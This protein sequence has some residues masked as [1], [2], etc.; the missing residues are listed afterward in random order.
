MRF[1]FVLLSALFLW[2]G[3][4]LQA[5]I[6]NCSISNLTATLSAPDPTTPCKYFVTLDFDH[7][8][9]TNQFSVKGNGT[10][11]GLFPYSQLPVQLGP[12]MAGT[13]PNVL[14]FIV[15]DAV[16][17]D[18]KAQVLLTLPACNS[19]T[20]NIDSLTVMPGDCI[21][22][23]NKYKLK[24]SFAVVNP[25]NQFVEMW[26]GNGQY[27]GLFP[28]SQLPVVVD[29]PA[30]GNTFDVLKVCMNDNPNCCK[31]LEFQA[32][33]CPGNNCGINN[34]DLSTDGCTND[35]TYRVKLNFQY[36]NPAQSDSFAVY[37]NGN[38][39]ANYAFGQ[40]PLVIPNFP[41]NGGP[42]DEIKIC[43][44]GSPAIPPC[45]VTRFIQ[46]PAC[47]PYPP[48]GVRDVVV[49]PGDC[50]S[51]ST[52]N[53]VL[54]F[55]YDTTYYNATDSFQLNGNG[56]YLGTFALNQL[57]VTIQNFE[58]NEKVFQNLRIC[59]GSNAA[60][61]QLC[62][63]EV[64]FIAPDCMPF[65]P[66][67]ITDIFTTTGGCTSDSTYRIRI[68]FQATNP[69]NGNFLLYANGTVVD[70]FPLTALP[71]NLSNFPWSGNATD[72]IKICILGNTNTSA[73]CC[74]TKVI[75][76]PN[77]L[78]P[79]E[80]FN[81]TALAGDCVPGTNGFSL[82]IDFEV[83]NP[84]NSSF[85]VYT[86]N[87]NLIGNFPI[88]QLPV[89]IP[90]F[91]SNGLPV[92]VVKICIND[93]PN[94]CRITEF[95][96][97][98]CNPTCDIVDFSVQT[99][100]C[101]GDS[102]YQVTINF[103]TTAPISNVF[104][105]WANGNLFG[106]FNLSQLPLTL[107]NF[108]WN[109]GQNDV[110][111]VCLLSP[112]ANQPLCCETKEFAVP[113][114]LF[115]NNCEITNL[116]VEVGECTGDSTYKIWVNFNVLN[117]NATSFTLWA[118]GVQFGTF[119]LNQL[120]LAIPNFPW[121]GGQNDFIKVCVQ[122]S[123][124]QGTLCCETKEFAVP[125]CLFNNN[126]EITN[127]AVQTG[128]CSSDSSYQLWVN[129]NVQNAPGN[130][131]G[132]WANGQFLGTFNLNQLPL[133]IPNFPW[134]GG[135]NDVI[136]VCFVNAAGPTNCCATKEFAVPQ[137]LFNGPC[138]INNLVLD[139]GQCTGDSTYQL[140]VNFS[141]QNAPS[142]SFQV[143]AN[144]V[145]LGNY[146]LNQLP[147]LIQNFPWNGGNFDVIKICLDGN[148]PGTVP[149]CISK[150]FEVPGCLSEN[151]D[152]WDT[153]VRATPCL[154]GQ[155]FALVSFNHSQGSAAGFNISGNGTNYGNFSYNDPQPIIIGPLAGDNSTDYVFLVK[156][157]THP[158][159][160]DDVKLGKIAC[161]S[162]VQDPNHGLSSMQVSPNPTSELLNVSLQFA[163]ISTP[164]EGDMQLIQ[165]DGRVTRSL[166]VAN[167]ASFS[168]TV[169]DL[170]SGVYRV[171]VRT[172]YGVAE[173]SFVKQ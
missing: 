137:C 7:S 73:P 48:C 46:V 126:C 161:A 50:T 81:L 99:G 63:R 104:G 42:N 114:C 36:V 107:P 29:Y 165:A 121:N 60:N 97:P 58:W 119:N 152:I 2:T 4:L 157:L 164:G 9:T 112:N 131:F 53:F 6:N 141:V 135:Q 71:L 31:T 1:T 129:F 127:L 101:T 133:A 19:G 167:A 43:I 136:K 115:S 87:G 78:G 37:A 94:C 18:C 108:P 120:P 95:Q 148:A 3:S 11:Y 75:E 44:N 72:E 34:L 5:Q 69:G 16:F 40:L 12:F 156:D 91:P 80:I 96:A 47:I 172:A 45:C 171:S 138:E 79:C 22:G 68:S 25:T 144:G 13:A 118:N 102:T 27:L 166:H 145:Q 143:W 122:N 168:L 111:K 76:A 10:N 61:L 55:A 56:S 103:G 106:T 24:V 33:N 66:C 151:C 155:F 38:F 142:T 124:T 26:A 123:N 105:V 64:Q 15:T 39:L 140:W 90:V 113:Q 20:C 147:L 100:Q 62:C 67:E 49:D 32:P 163:G 132:V 77:C 57:P 52:F 150:E 70:T 116:A 170:P 173:G 160:R 89:T 169:A 130:L 54:N 93:N 85:D 88:S 146:N 86:Q 109:G 28:I 149:C 153:A 41:W 74:R 158:D 159:C 110:I 125:Q 51:D 84:G 128:Q 98:V 82:K 59:I 8:G 134:N 154:C 23:S 14:E 65:G 83:Q 139:P 35:S 17:P 117:S 162:F 92:G 21:P 30:S